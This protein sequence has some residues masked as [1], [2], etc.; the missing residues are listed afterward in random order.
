MEKPFKPSSP[1][2]AQTVYVQA[3]E[4]TFRDLVQRLTGA[5]PADGSPTRSSSHSAVGAGR[6]S[7]KLHARHGSSIRN[8]E[9]QLAVPSHL[10]PRSSSPSISSPV[11]PLIYDPL[12]S[13][14]E[15]AE[16]RAIAEKGFYLHPSH[17]GGSQ[18]ELLPLFPMSS[19]SQSQCDSE[20]DVDKS[21]RVIYARILM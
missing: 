5:P 17:R 20:I 1:A 9:I 16:E 12:F 10:F 11:T 19:P 2:A 6:S 21:W 13:P 3:D 15:D 14:V 18:P 4:H 8:L 7:Y